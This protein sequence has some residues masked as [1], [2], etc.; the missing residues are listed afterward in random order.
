VRIVVARGLRA[1][2]VG[3]A[4]RRGM[5]AGEVLV[6]PRCR[7]VHT[8]GMRFAIDVVFLDARGRVVDVRHRV[9]PFRVVGC[10]RAAAVVETRAG[11]CGWL[12][13]PASPPGAPAGP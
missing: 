4:F 7:S 10:R 8:F 9:R 3:L 6:I 11:E 12:V 2:L 1:R 13:S 5:E